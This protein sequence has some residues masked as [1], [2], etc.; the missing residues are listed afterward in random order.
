MIQAGLQPTDDITI[1]YDVEPLK[2]NTKAAYLQS[3]VKNYHEYI[4]EATKQP[5]KSSDNLV[6]L[7]E[8]IHEQMEVI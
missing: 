5:L 6:N 8:I 4:S 7:P 2:D 3:V 1:V